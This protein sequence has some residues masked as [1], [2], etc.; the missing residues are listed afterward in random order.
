MVSMLHSINTQHAQS[1]SSVDSSHCVQGTLLLGTGQAFHMLWHAAVLF[2]KN[3]CVV[4]LVDHRQ[5]IDLSVTC[6]QQTLRR[7]ETARTVT[8]LQLN[9]VQQE[10][11]SLAQLVADLVVLA[12]MNDRIASYSNTQ[13]SCCT[14]YILCIEPAL[15]LPRS[16]DKSLCCALWFTSAKKL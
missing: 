9:D 5:D 8:H 7:P 13:R 10:E 15:S 2:M 4:R 16:C 1:C 3:G 11:P 6:Q 14:L 12:C